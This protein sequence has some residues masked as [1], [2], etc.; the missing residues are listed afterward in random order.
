[1]H[2]LSAP[3][4]HTFTDCRDIAPTSFWYDFRDVCVGR[5]QGGLKANAVCVGLLIRLPPALLR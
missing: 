4:H 5:D 2:P 3:A 1:M